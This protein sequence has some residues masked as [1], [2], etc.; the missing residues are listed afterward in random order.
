MRGMV[1][2]YYIYAVGG[3]LLMAFL[4]ALSACGVFTD[5][6]NK[7]VV[8]G[9]GVEVTKGKATTSESSGQVLTP[10]K[11]DKAVAAKPSK[12]SK[13]KAVKNKNKV[14]FCPAGKVRAY[15]WIGIEAL[16]YRFQ[17]RG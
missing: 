10:P 11:S 4:P 17:Y 5:N 8:N 15:R 6:S 16:S 3:S 7:Y 2:T 14:S 12:P 1:C 9:S 13:S